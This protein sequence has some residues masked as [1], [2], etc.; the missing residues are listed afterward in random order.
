MWINC[1]GVNPAVYATIWRNKYNDTL[2][3]YKWTQQVNDQDTTI[4]VNLGNP[5][6]IS[7]VT[8]TPTPFDDDGEYECR[9]QTATINET[10]R[11]TIDGISSSLITSLKLSLCV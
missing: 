6:S 1:T 11:T 9:F 10:N 4:Y 8:T 2:E 5:P 7:L 3:Q